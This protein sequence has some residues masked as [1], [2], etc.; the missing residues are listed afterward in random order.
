[1]QLIR[2]ELVLAGTGLPRYVSL[3][4]SLTVPAFF[5]SDI[6]LSHYPGY[7][8]ASFLARVIQVP[9]NERDGSLALPRAT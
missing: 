7:S 5:P 9:S 8:F 2:R 6:S 3:G 1:M 4:F